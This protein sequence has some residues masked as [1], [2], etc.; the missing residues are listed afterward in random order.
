MSA[1]A[2]TVP[3]CPR[4]DGFGYHPVDVTSHW[5]RHDWRQLLDP[6]VSWQRCAC[7]VDHGTPLGSLHA[8]LSQR[9][10]TTLVRDVDTWQT[11]GGWQAGQL[12]DGQCLWHWRDVLIALPGPLTDHVAYLMV[13]TLGVQ[14]GVQRAELV[15]TLETL[16]APPLPSDGQHP[17]VHA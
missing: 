14:R 2:S 13:S 9:L 12:A 7:A 17:G 4:C 16:G 1:A 8:Q 11:Y 10:L 3:D 6:T 15:K 5:Y